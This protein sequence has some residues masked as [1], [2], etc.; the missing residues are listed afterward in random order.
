MTAGLQ[1]FGETCGPAKRRGRETRAERAQSAQ[2]ALLQQLLDRLVALMAARGN[3]AMKLLRP[4]LSSLLALSEELD[5]QGRRERTLSVAYDQLGDASLRR[6]DLSGATTYFQRALQIDEAAAADPSDKQAQRDLS[7]SYERLG[8][9]QLQSGQATEALG[10]YQKCLEIRQKLA[11]A[12]PSDA[13]A[14]RDLSVSYNKLGDVQRRSGQTTEALGSYQKGLEISRK[15]A[16]ADPSDAQ[17]QLDLVFS[18]VKLGQVNQVANE[19]QK[20][21]AW[22]EQA[23]VILKRLKREQRLA[24]VKQPWIAMAERFIALCQK[25][26]AGSI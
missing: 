10:S 6:G 8:D 11:A 14:L 26:L 13:Q 24:P 1:R 23:L 17:A 19:F 21:I 25:A 9:V 4:E 12:D 18:F 7:I 3:V 2:P 15:L 22:F 20:A 5:R 16:A